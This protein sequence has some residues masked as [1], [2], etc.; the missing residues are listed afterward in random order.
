[1]S[2]TEAVFQLPG[3]ELIDCPI[4]LRLAEAMTEPP[5]LRISVMTL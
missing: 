3:I 4:K 1:M 5:V 2:K